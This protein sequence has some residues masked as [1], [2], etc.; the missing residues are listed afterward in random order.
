MKCSI[1]IADSAFIAKTAIITGN[2]EIGNNVHIGEYVVIE[3]NIKIDDNTKIANHVS[4]KGNTTIGKNNKIFPSSSIGDEPQDLKYMGEE[5]FLEIGDNNLIREFC[6]INRGTELGG[7][8]TKIGN[9][10]L[11]M[12]Y[13]HIAH[14]CIIGNHNIIANNVNFGGHVTTGDHVTIGGMGAIHQFSRIGDGSMLAVYS[15]LTQDLPPYCLAEGNRAKVI[16]LNKVKLRKIFER[17]EII[18]LINESY[19]R[20]FSRTDSLKKIAEKELEIVSKLELDSQLL[21]IYKER[22]NYISEFI[23]STTRGIALQRRSTDE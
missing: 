8:Y 19:K 23:S 5:S 13:V 6:T 17:R 20:I 21:D 4:I 9:N 18:D 7:S 15:C 12:A 10:T 3:G 16:G 22:I 14:D 2:V 1:K 11:L